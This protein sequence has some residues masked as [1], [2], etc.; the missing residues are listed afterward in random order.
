MSGSTMGRRPVF[1][2][3]MGAISETQKLRSGQKQG[4][5]LKVT[6]TSLDTGRPM[7]T[8][9]RGNKVFARLLVDDF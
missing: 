7:N 8:K 3:A 9:L 4:G 6:R 1:V 2:L 5:R